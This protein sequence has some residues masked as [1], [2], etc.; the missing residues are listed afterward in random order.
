MANMKPY[1]KEIT[2]SILAFIFLWFV[3]TNAN[4][5]LGNAYL[6]AIAISIILL[7][8]NILVFD[9]KVDVTFQ[10]E[11][12]KWFEAVIQGVIGWILILLSS[13]L[14]F[15]FADPGMANFGAI[16]SSL[17]AANPAFA[18]SVILNWAV[19]SFAIGYGET[20]LFGRLLEFLTDR[21][22]IKITRKNMLR[23]GLVVL[24]VVLSGIFALFHV[25]AKGVDAT[26][27]LLVVGIMMFISLMMIVYNNGETRQAVFVH[28]LANGVAGLALI[29]SG[30]FK[31]V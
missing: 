27:S 1:M 8:I 18:N 19:I 10:K 13:Y 17:G 16:I 12:G 30:G 14:I 21:F 29:F 7:L 4:S 15:K 2:L 3:L 28:I 31:I 24:I 11:K 6:W 22:G 20:Q 9:K 26:N 25:T 23:T 5:N